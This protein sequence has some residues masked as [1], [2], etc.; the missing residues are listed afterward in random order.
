MNSSRINAVNERGVST[1]RRENLIVRD[2]EVKLFAA[3]AKSRTSSLRVA[4]FMIAMASTPWQRAAVEFSDHQVERRGR[5]K[6]QC[7]TIPVERQEA[8]LQRI[9]CSAARF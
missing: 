2:N 9:T 1:G 5:L 7:K 6:S 3:F 8:V 4:A